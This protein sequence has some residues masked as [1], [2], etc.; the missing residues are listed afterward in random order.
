MYKKFVDTGKSVEIITYSVLNN[1]SVD[2]PEIII[3]YTEELAKCPFCGSDAEIVPFQAYRFIHGMKVKCK[4]CHCS[5]VSVTDST[6]IYGV[7]L[8]LPESLHKVI[9]LWNNRTA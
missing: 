7:K 4:K 5:T 8:S 1:V 9:A 2:D 3:P 6:D